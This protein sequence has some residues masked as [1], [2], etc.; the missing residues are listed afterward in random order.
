MSTSNKDIKTLEKKFQLVKGLFEI[1][2]ENNARHTSQTVLTTKDLHCEQYY[3]MGSYH[4]KVPNIFYYNTDS[5]NVKSKVYA[6]IDNI[7]KDQM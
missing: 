1:I 3:L 5:S 6:S 4:D 7:E 2:Y